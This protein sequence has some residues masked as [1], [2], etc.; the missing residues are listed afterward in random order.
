MNKLKT[1]IKDIDFEFET[2]G[3]VFS[4]REV[5]PGTKL[6]AESLEVKGRSLLDLGCGYGVIGITA[7]KSNPEIQVTMSDDSLRATKLAKRNIELNRIK[8]TKVVLSD[9]FSEINERFDVI[10]SNPPLGM[11]NELVEE[12]INDSVDHL[13]PDG[14]IWIVTQNRFKPF[15]QRL[16]EKYHGSFEIVARGKE[17]FVAKWGR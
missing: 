15:L 13:D 1:K 16:F 8:N 4:A 6:L 17:H 2:I 9:G 12:L 14:E 10:I 7:A 3:G 11:G 5:D